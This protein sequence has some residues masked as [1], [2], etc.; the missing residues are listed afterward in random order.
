M[1][2]ITVRDLRATLLLAAGISAL[3]LL[4]AVIVAIALAAG[5]RH[6]LNFPFPGVQPTLANATAIFANNAKLMTGVL[7]LALVVQAPWLENRGRPAPAWHRALVRACD[8][9]LALPVAANVIVVGAALGAYGG[10]MARA[11]LPHGPVELAAFA[12]SLTVYLEARRGPIRP[13]GAA[14]LIALSFLT[15]ALA[16]LLETYITV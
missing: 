12:L 15:L 5:V 8:T 11:M 13:R 14:A 3:A 2:T 1:S 10:R 16:A 9:L 4:A 6:A 7:A